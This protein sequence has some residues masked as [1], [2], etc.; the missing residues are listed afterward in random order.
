MG[1]FVGV[2]TFFNLDYLKFK[3]D[4]LDYYEQQ[5]RGSFSYIDLRIPQ[6]IFMCR[7]NEKCNPKNDN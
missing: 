6:K 2:N 7:I 4:K 3:E 5:N 1:D